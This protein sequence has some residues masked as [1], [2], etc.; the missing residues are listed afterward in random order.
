MIVEEIDSVY[1]KVAQN[2][3]VEYELVK[4]VGDEISKEQGKRKLSFD[5][6]RKNLDKWEKM[7]LELLPFV[8]KLIEQL[9]DTG[10]NRP[11]KISVAGICKALNLPNKRIDKLPMCK[12]EI[13][14]HMESQEHYWAREL[15]WAVESIEKSEVR[16]NWKQIRDLINLRKGN[17]ELALNDLKDMDERV[18]D[19]VVSLL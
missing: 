8:K 19:I 15:V 3:G 18:H 2:I 6:K 5:T 13:R 11:E 14:K 7:D 4:L 16:L 17:V 12:E 1:L 10:E 9:Q